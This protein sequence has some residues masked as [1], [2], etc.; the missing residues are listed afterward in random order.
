MKFATKQI[1]DLVDID[2][3]KLIKPFFGNYFELRDDPSGLHFCNKSGTPSSRSFIYPNSLNWENGHL[4]KELII[5]ACNKEDAQLI[6]ELINIGCLLGYPSLEDFPIPAFVVDEND[7]DEVNILNNCIV[8]KKYYEEYYAKEPT[9]SNL[10]LGCLI[11]SKS[12]NNLKYIYM[13]NKYRFSLKLS[14]LSPHSLHPRHGDVFSGYEN[15]YEFHVSGA[16]A[17]LS[18]YSIIE[19]LKVDIKS[20]KDNQ[21]IIINNGINLLNPKIMEDT[22][23]RLKEKNIDGEELISFVV[24][25]ENRN[26]TSKVSP[27]FGTKSSFNVYNDVHDIDL[28]I[29]EAIHYCSYIRNFFLA[30]GF[31]E[32][33]SYLSPYDIHN[34]QMLARRLLLTHFDYWKGER[35]KR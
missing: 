1:F 31:S 34:V 5:D 24:R 2:K 19:D 21:R 14:S 17:F 22:I 26:L 11:A 32:V 10:Y 13:L 25:G 33:N 6:S 35:R 28:T 12:F 15:D 20:S 27:A 23:Y 3:I 4:A 8:K 7:I 29:V 9:R 30:H 18:A 16:Y